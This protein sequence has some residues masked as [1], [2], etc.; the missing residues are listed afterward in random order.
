MSPV[1]LSADKR[2]HRAHVRPSRRRAQ[3]RAVVRPLVKYAVLA[4]VLLVAVY[5]GRA[6]VAEAAMLRVDRIVVHGNDRLTEDDV[7]TLLEG[8]TGQNLVWTD[9]EAWRR[10]LMASPWVREASIRRSL[11]STVDVVISERQPMGIARIGRDLFLVDDRGRVID[12]YGPLYAELD[13][14]I[15]DGLTAP[16]ATESADS[17]TPGDDARARLAA[18]LMAALRTRPEVA[19]RVSQVDVKDLHN[20]AVILN[21]DPAVIYVG[22]D[23]FLTRL[24]SYLELVGA[25]RER[26]EEIDYVDLRFDERIYVRPVQAKRR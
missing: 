3:W 5:R 18:R 15:I 20:A 25:V 6:M 10:Q 23:R 16:T 13:L 7:R 14:P 26:V 17:S 24:E 1:A 22:E 8:L 21:G 2:F 12:R 9:L 4:L 19:K 11:P